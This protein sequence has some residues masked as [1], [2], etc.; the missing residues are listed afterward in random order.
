[1]FPM[2]RSCRRRSRRIWSA[3]RRPP[4]HSPA[5]RT[6]SGPAEAG[7]LAGPESP[8]VSGVD[9]VWVSEVGTGLEE[10]ALARRIVVHTKAAF[11]RSVPPH[12]FRDAAATS[13]AID[14]P[15]HIGDASLVLATPGRDNRKAL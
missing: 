15:R 6:R 2:R 9:A 7:P 4:A 11:G 8:V 1:M 3:P 12:W 13:I 10:G 14:N 5:R